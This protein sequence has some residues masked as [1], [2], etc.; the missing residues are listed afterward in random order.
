MK[1]PSIGVLIWVALV[2]CV[3][4]GGSA[5]VATSSSGE[6][7]VTYVG[8]AG[9]LITVGDHKILIDAMFDGF[10]GGYRLPA[11]VKDALVNAQPPF[12]GVDL[13]LVTHSHADHFDADMVR[14]HMEAN[15]HAILV[16]GSQVTTQLADLGSRVVTVTAVTGKTDTTI[17]NGIRV[18]AIYLSHGVF[19]PGEPEIVNYGYVV[20][21]GDV[22]FFHTG[23]ID[24]VTIG[25][26]TLR[27]YG[28]ADKGIDFAF[29]PYFFLGGRD[30]APE[31][32]AAIGARFIIGAHYEYT[33]SPLVR[34][35]I[36]AAYPDAV[37]FA[38]GRD[39]DSWVLPAS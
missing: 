25:V 29:V 3:L 17:Q 21:I 38:R 16:A 34:G 23:D 9:F 27:S 26:E 24:P 32:V 12:D 11:N 1:K 22:C 37:V 14:R 28:L 36:L 4:A 20:T 7:R 2:G 8:N 30:A 19:P 10:P 13:I 18:Q 35:A 31:F 33:M 15:P 39:L 5:A 6:V